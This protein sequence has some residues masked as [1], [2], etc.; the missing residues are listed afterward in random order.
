MASWGET[1]SRLVDRRIQRPQTNSAAITALKA[2]DRFDGMLVVDKATSTVY[3]FDADS[4]AVA[5]PTVLVPDAGSGRWIATGGGGGT[6]VG[7][8][9]ISAVRGASDAALAAYTRTGNTILA[10][11][12][13]AFNPEDGVTFAVGDRYLLK[14]GAA[15]ADN[16]PYRIDAIGGVSAKW[17]M[18]RVGDADAS[19]EVTAGMLVYVSEGTA[20]GDDWYYLST[21]DT[22]T[23][24]TTAL[25]FVK[26][27][28]LTELTSVETR[29]SA[30]ECA[31]SDTDSSLGS[32]ETRLS[33]EECARSD[34]DSSLGSVET[35][36]SAEECARSDTDSSL[37]SVETRLSAEECARSDTDSSLGSVETRLS[38]EECARSDTDSSLGSVETRLS[39]EESTRSD[40]DA[41]LD[42]RVD[43]LDTGTICFFLQEFREVDANGD[44]GNLAAHGGIL[45]SDSTPILRGGTNEDTEIS[46]ATGNVDIIS[47]N[48]SL[49]E[50]FD[51]SS[52]VTVRMWVSSGAVGPDA[53][54]FTINTSW[55]QNAQVVDTATDS[56]PSANR[57]EITA[58]IAN[59]DIAA[60]ADTLTM[61]LIPAAHAQDSVQLHGVRLEYSRA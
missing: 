20:N 59:A 52:D 40:A 17:Q 9:H 36:L 57:H 39:T 21:D 56:S 53:A 29:L 32:V 34:T 45:A 27:P 48:C 1:L 19:A 43:V 26:V 11:A 30:E 10:D 7:A 37:G 55:D 13:G 42:T 8:V 58:T 50:D 2:K 35:R 41:S 51:A 28:T 12:N 15:G 44:V 23:L 25:T 14:D 49:P 16:G 31:R 33:A 24:N 46:W 4:T 5:G 6:G 38:A 3:Q 18:T 61:Q 47:T 54:T 22:I 60:G